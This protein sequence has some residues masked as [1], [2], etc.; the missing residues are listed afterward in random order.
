M[1]TVQL[2]KLGIKEIDEQHAHLVECLDRLEL[3]VGK[4]QG[5][6][7]ALDALNSL[8]DYVEVHFT[9]EEAFMRQ[10]GYP[11]LDEHIAEHRQIKAELTR[12]S[13][14]VLEGGEIDQE[15]LG[16]IREWIITHIGIEDVEYA[17]AFAI[18]QA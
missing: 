3:W 11:K 7:A 1:R 8:N 17:T 9:F 16:L 12:L 4:G 5:F 10:H 14:Q 15:L 13:R 18:P 6:A 2:P